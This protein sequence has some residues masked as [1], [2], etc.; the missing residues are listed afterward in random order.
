MYQGNNIL[1][2]YPALTFLLPAR[3]ALSYFPGNSLCLS[4]LFST[5]ICSKMLLCCPGKQLPPSY[6]HWTGY[7]HPRFR[8]CDV[9]RLLDSVRL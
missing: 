2:S 3:W 9:C 5:M 4:T 7:W 6:S 1:L 8:S